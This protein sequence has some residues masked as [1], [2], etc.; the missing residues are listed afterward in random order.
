MATQAIAVV[1]R[2][3]TAGTSKARFVVQ[4]TSDARRHYI[5]TRTPRG[6]WQC[7]CPRWIFGVKQSDGTRRRVPC[8]H[9]KGLQ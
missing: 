7:S 4:S 6:K 8:K 3:F 1:S 5:V 2:Q 9:I